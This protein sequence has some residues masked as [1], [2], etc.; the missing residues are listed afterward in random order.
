MNNNKLKE[1]FLK[2]SGIDLTDF[3]VNGVFPKYNSNKGKW[4]SIQRGLAWKLY[5][6]WIENKLIQSKNLIKD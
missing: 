5:A 1:E 6:E 4:G 2:H 3:E